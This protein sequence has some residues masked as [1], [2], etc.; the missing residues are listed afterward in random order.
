MKKLFILFILAIPF[1]GFAQSNSTQKSPV[2]STAVP[3]SV[4]I[5]SERLSRIDKMCEEAIANQDIPGVVALVAK[6]G[7]I[8][9]HKAFGKAN[10]NRDIK[11]DDIFRIASQ[12][13]AVTATAVMMLW[14]KGLFRLDDPISKWIPEFKNPK[15]LTKFNYS[16]T[17]FVGVPAKQEITIRHLLT[18]TS[19]IGYGI[20]DTDESF[21][22][23]YQKAGI[24]EIASATPITTAENIKKLAKMPL[25]F[26]P[27]EKYSY[28]M[29]LDVLAYFVE[30]LS[31]MTYDKFLANQI[32][33]PLGMNDTYFY[34]PK[35]KE[36]RLVGLYHFY[37]GK[38]QPQSRYG[39]YEPDYPIK[40]IRTIFSGGG[41][42][43][44]TV[45]DYA[46][47]L[48]MYLNNGELN[49]KRI[50][51]RT[52][53]EMM[54]KNHISDFWGDSGSHYGLAFAVVNEKG[55]NEGGNGSEGTF[56]WGGAFNTQYFADPEQNIIG[57]IHKQTLGQWKDKTSW[58]FKQ[59]V[60]QAVI[61]ADEKP[62]LTEGKAENVGM[63]EE[64]L[65]HIDKM[66]QKAIADDD[67]PG[68]VVLVARNGKIVYHKAFGQADNAANRPLK[69]DDIFRIA[70]QT[71][72]IT[73]TAVMMLW[74]EGH[75]QL[76][77][78]ISKWIPEFKNPKILDKFTFEN[79]TYT[80]S[81]AKSEITIRQ[82]MTHTSG[83]G[84]GVIDPNEGMRRLY[85]KAGIQEFA[86]QQA[87]YT[88][89]ENVKKI[90]AMPLHFNPG[91]KY[92]YGMGLD[93]LVY[94][95]EIISGK[96]FDQF[97]KE[98]IF[99]PLGMKDTYFHLPQ[100]KA[101]RLVPVQIWKD[102]KWQHEPLTSYDPNFPLTG[103]KKFCS[104][105][106]GLSSTITDYAIF[107]QMYL[108]GGKINGV[109]ILSPTTIQAMMTNQAGDKW[110]YDK[111][112]LGLA[113]G[114]VNENGHVE[115]GN[116]SVDTFDWGG[117]F[118]TSYFADPNEQVIG[119]IFKQTKNTMNDKTAWQFRQMVFQAIDN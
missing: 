58:Q 53:I 45:K 50:L 92:Q 96:P 29:G 39:E 107:L 98:R 70:S 37:Q 110:D 106:A 61:T 47:F 2:L 4:G 103:S 41:G 109:Q 14:E 81:P 117:Y 9:Y 3:E 48:Q 105:G 83:I 33:E 17:S 25:H 114:L 88:T 84:Y 32:F 89:A 118:N 100:E 60:G 86:S 119:L 108:N 115:G 99:E 6:D 97:A 18:H 101:S 82:L 13:K 34:L 80:S 27:G 67:I 15:V 63:S 62:T 5:S 90:A 43:S 19:G 75:F 76:D 74:E 65:E 36:E 57:I 94:F 22:M 113:F 51:S 55:Q 59:L 72:A 52:T 26:N 30:I 116:G 104:G 68:A 77:D 24:K 8:I 64:R 91:E 38:W 16:D 40:E 49:G 71:K 1:W 21:R 93:V 28:S 10:V 111:K 56:S 66:C 20:I 85:K 78:P 7:K 23:L 54:M 112:Y 73:A 87:G 79:D 102:K 35:E 11:T 42:L 12:T 31:G 95:V 44:C 69:K 46:T